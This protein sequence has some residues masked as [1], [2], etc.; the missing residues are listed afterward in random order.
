MGKTLLPEHI[1][2]AA[3]QDD[4]RLRRRLGDPPGR[5]D[6]GA[7]AA[8]PFPQKAGQIDL[9]RADRLAVIVKIMDVQGTLPVCRG[10]I[11][12]QKVAQ[13]VTFTGRHGDLQHFCRRRAAHTGVVPVGLH[14]YLLDHIHELCFCFANA[15]APVTVEDV[16]LRRAGMSIFDEHFLHGILNLFHRRDDPVMT[17]RLQVAD[18][19]P[20]QVFSDLP[21]APPH[22]L[23]RFEDR[24]GDLDR[25]KLN[26]AAVPFP[27]L[28]KGNLSPGAL[29]IS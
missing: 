12:G 3:L 11:I 22:G 27:D 5:P 17:G 25:V 14:E 19:L 7:A 6:P 23:D 18:H 20:G 1:V 16:R 26:H 15:G 24:I 10:K 4:R 28:L 8:E 29:I 13:V 9:Q 2:L 21:V